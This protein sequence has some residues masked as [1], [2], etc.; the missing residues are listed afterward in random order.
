VHARSFRGR[1]AHGLEPR[2]IARVV[3]EHCREIVIS[4][5]G[6]LIEQVGS[7]ALLHQ[8]RERADSSILVAEDRRDAIGKI[9]IRREDPALSISSKLREELRSLLALRDR[10]MCGIRRSKR[11]YD[12]RDMHLNA[13]ALGISRSIDRLYRGFCLPER[14]LLTSNANDRRQREQLKNC[15]VRPHGSLKEK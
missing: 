6:K 12:F 2:E 14:R 15:A 10:E 7:A 9:G 3:V 1:E 8:I 11:M 5:A 13:L 4:R